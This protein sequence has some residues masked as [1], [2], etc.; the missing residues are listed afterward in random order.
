MSTYNDILDEAMDKYGIIIP[1]E[2]EAIRYAVPEETYNGWVLVWWSDGDF[3]LDV[4]GPMGMPF[5]SV[6][7]SN[8]LYVGPS[9]GAAGLGE[10]VIGAA[11]IGAQIQVLDLEMFLL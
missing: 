10:L 11:D 4:I 9:I 2:R 3:D 7:G 1:E 5:A 6:I 8:A